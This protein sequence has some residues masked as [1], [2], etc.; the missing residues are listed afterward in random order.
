MDLFIADLDAQMVLDSA[1]VK[2]IMKCLETLSTNCDAEE[3][4]NHCIYC[5]AWDLWNA[6]YEV[7]AWLGQ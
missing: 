2:E 1:L 3:G 4:P 6:L 5:Q 7:N